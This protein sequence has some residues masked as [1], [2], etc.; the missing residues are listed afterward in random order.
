MVYL[1]SNQKKRDC[2]VLFIAGT[3]PL[4]FSGFGQYFFNWYGPLS[5]LNGL[6]IWYQRPLGPGSTAMTGFFNNPN[7]A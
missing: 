5:L 6:I 4:I 7:Y 1:N 3:I 2:I